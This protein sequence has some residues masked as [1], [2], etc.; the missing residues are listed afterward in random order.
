MTKNLLTEDGANICELIQAQAEARPDAI[1]VVFYDQKIT[2]RELNEKSGQLAKYLITLKVI[3]SETLVGIYLERSLKLVVAILAIFKAKAAYVPIDPSYP[4]DRIKYML[5]DAEVAALLT[6]NSL[7]KTLPL[8]NN[9]QIICVDDENLLN[10]TMPDAS[11]NSIV[12]T[13]SYQLNSLAY[14][15]YTSGSTGKPKGVMIEHGSLINAYYAWKE[16]Y[17]L[18]ENDVHLQMA[19]F[20]FDVFV[21]DMVR[22]LCSGSKL[23]LC[24][25]EA[26]LNPIK[27]YKLILKERVTCAEFVPATL[28]KL[29]DYLDYTK[30][31]LQFM[32]LL[33]CG[34]DNWSVGEYKNFKRFCSKQ[35]RLI[36][37]YGLTETT[38]DS[39]YFEIT[40]SANTEFSL[41]D[42]Q[43]VP[44]GKPFKNIN[45][46]LFDENLKEVIPGH[47]GEIY[48][49]G[50]GL[51]RAYLNLPE[52][53]KKKF[54][55]HTFDN[56]IE[57][58]LYKT[59]D[60]AKY[61]PDG[62]IEFVGRLDD[63]V[64]LHGHRIELT[65]IENILNQHQAINQ[66]LVF[67]RSGAGQSRYLM[68][69]LTTKTGFNIT[70]KELK[71]FLN[72]HLP[73]YMVPSHFFTLES[74]PLTPNGKL[75]RKFLDSLIK[76]PFQSNKITYKSST[77]Q[78]LIEIMAKILHLDE[79]EINK[80]FA[81]LGVNSLSLINII[82]E[83]ER[84]FST[85]ISINNLT[86][87]S[88]IENLANA[89]QNSLL[90]IR[91]LEDNE[92]SN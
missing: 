53:T 31:S 28:R 68:A 83:L 40:D 65:E 78:A 70:A 80:T 57:Q 90:M 10:S 21:G 73:N 58:R 74:L 79:I 11:N 66:S 27:L 48:I 77:Q 20:S 75:D 30:Q 51:A 55:K 2:Y 22:A 38:I 26:L 14:V 5:A 18:N 37:S 8:N 50:L 13:S 35:T 19:S 47:T 32:R 4:Q 88:T 61:L 6:Q 1:A 45:I 44:I 24:P 76:L 81:E 34:S 3:Q 52:L 63:Q 69:C 82:T 42:E 72:R 36:N 15:L 23:V 89:V 60:L 25:R 7:L 91:S 92:H 43:S 49:G 54:I 64:K 41:S 84:I 62:N 56:G 85:R 59:G 12:K 46:Y 39:T 9:A 71:Q 16:A 17:E 87:C 29:I 33:I 86:P 67:V